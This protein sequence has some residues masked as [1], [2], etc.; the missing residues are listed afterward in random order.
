[1]GREDA[2]KEI[3]RAVRIV[4]GEP[5]KG[6]LLEVI[7]QL[8]KSRAQLTLVPTIMEGSPSGPQSTVPEGYMSDGP[9][10]VIRG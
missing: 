9:W 10:E 7:S 6:K 5:T 2:I 4:Y 8:S 1:M 3:E